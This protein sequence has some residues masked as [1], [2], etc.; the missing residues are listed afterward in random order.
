MMAELSFLLDV[1]RQLLGG[2]PLTIELVTV[3]VA[4]GALLAVA[5]ALARS[6]SRLAAVIVSFYVF[7]FRGSPLLLQMFF[8][9]YGLGQFAVVRESFAWPALRDPTFCAILSLA[10]NTAAYTSE[11]LRGGL[12]SVPAGAIEAGRAVGM[13]RGL[14][15]RRVVLPLAIRQALPAYSNEL[16]EMVKSTSLA[17]I[18]TLM[19]VSGIA[20]ALVSATYRAIEVLSCAGAI[21][22]VLIVLLTRGVGWVE[23]WLSPAGSRA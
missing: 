5:M 6:A 3:S 7:V 1:T 13:S 4:A 9:Y 16:I 17:S 20:Y 23:N 10:L 21:Y 12:A 18:V 15:L 11:I 8:I 19:E 22:L 14:L 2:L